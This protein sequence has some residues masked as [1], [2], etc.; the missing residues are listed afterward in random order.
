M[1]PEK[2]EPGNESR[3]CI[4]ETSVGI[5][6]SISYNAE[7]DIDNDSSSINSEE[8]QSLRES[9]AFWSTKHISHSALNDLLKVLS[10][11]TSESLSKD[12]RTL[13]STRVNIIVKYHRNRNE[14]LVDISSVLRKCVLL[15]SSDKETE[16]FCYPFGKYLNKG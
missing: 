14:I 15:P 13:L 6:S 7:V 10:N 16:Y 4:L 1:S 2:T 9:L 3:A 8:S 11:F 5:C 12:S